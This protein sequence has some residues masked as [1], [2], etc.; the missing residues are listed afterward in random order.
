MPPWEYKMNNTFV[1]YSTENGQP[2]DDGS[3]AFS[4]LQATDFCYTPTVFS[5]MDD[6]AQMARALKEDWRM[7]NVAPGEFGDG[8][9]TEDYGQGVSAMR[10]RIETADRL[11]APLPV[12]HPGTGDQLLALAL[13][14]R[15]PLRRV[16]SSGPVALSRAAARHQ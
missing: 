4:Y 6:P 12:Y 11:G 10:K 16:V 13:G 1:V 14:D 8:T 15:H 5:L 2:L 7:V 9:Y 3:D